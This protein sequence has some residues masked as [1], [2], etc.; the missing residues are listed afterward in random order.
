MNTATEVLEQR[1]KVNK[2]TW[3]HINAVRNQIN[4]VIALLDDK[5]ATHDFSKLT[6]PE[7]D[8]FAE[9]TP[10][11]A[12]STYGSDE[13]KGFLEAMKP[14][15]AHHYEENRHHPEHFQDGVNGMN[16]VD[17]IEMLCDW[18]AATLRHNN[19]DIFKSIEINRKRFGISGQLAQILRN[20]IEILDDGPA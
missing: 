20:S 18:K 1:E 2:E 6:T 7:V 5:A 11:L 17:L 13:Y 4:N 19:G 16:L 9:Y 8:T 12:T 10:K 3:K 14:A 15:L